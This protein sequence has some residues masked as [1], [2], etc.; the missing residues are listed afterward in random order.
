MNT[1]CAYAVYPLAL[2]ICISTITKSV[3]MDK[4]HDAVICNAYV[5]YGKMRKFPK[6]FIQ[7]PS[8]NSRFNAYSAFPKTGVDLRASSKL[9]A[10]VQITYGANITEAKK[11]HILT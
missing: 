11:C 2:P 7:P 5:K 10:R 6:P 4:Q 3:D 1:L 8:H 9:C